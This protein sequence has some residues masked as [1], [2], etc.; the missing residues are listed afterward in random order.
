[1]PFTEMWSSK[2]DRVPAR[3]ITFQASR[4]Y[5]ALQNVL[6]AVSKQVTFCAVAKL[7]EWEH[8]R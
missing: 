3:L 2:C 8:G 5:P 7:G 1:M 4:L 6:G